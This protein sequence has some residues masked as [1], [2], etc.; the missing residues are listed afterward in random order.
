MVGLNSLVLQKVHV[1]VKDYS[2]AVNVWNTFKMNTICDY[3]DL[4]L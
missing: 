2:Q 3:R 4:Y 1:L